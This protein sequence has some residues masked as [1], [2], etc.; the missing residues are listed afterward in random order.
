MPIHTRNSLGLALTLFL[1][2][3]STALAQPKIGFPGAP[4][5]FGQVL[6][7]QAV[8]HQFEIRNTGKDTLFISRVKPACGCT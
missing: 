5:D 7:D 8:S 4:W 1:L 6:Q 2:G 3:A